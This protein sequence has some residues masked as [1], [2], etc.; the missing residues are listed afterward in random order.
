MNREVA[1]AEKR[2]LDKIVGEN[3]RIERKRRNM[4]REEL[5][6]VLDIS[7]SLLS[8][9]ERGKR[10]VTQVTLGR[11]MSA[12]NVTSDVLRA[13]FPG[14]PSDRK[15]SDDAVYFKKAS[16]LITQ[17]SETELEMLCYSI[18]GILAMRAR[19]AGVEVPQNEAKHEQ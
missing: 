8:L 5:A 12:F 10:G 14:A 19:V 18:K 4:S 15:I 6:N 11:L 7:T 17:L 13:E 16:A 2:K 1:K 3:V 9:I